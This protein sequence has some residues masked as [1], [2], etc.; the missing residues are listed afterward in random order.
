MELDSLVDLEEMAPDGLTGLPRLWAF[1]SRLGSEVARIRR[2]GGE[3]ALCLIDLDSLGTVNARQ[4]WTVGDQV[5]RLVARHF[6]EVRGEDAAF[7]IGEDSFAIIF[8]EVGLHGARA[9]MRRLE[10]AI[11][12]DEECPR[13]SISWGAAGLRTADPAALVAD[14]GRELLKVKR[15][16]ARRPLLCV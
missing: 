7:R 15:M 2:H 5:L 13:I 9:A 4:G 3:L 12:T 14:A 16:R 11:K 6:S 8:V 10:G 1:E